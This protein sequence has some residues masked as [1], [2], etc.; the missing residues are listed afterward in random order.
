MAQKDTLFKNRP[1][2]PITVAEKIAP[3]KPTIEKS[4]LLEAGKVPFIIFL[5]FN[6][7]ILIIYAVLSSL[8]LGVNL[9][10]TVAGVP[11]FDLL[12]FPITLIFWFIWVVHNG[13]N[14]FLIL[15]GGYTAAKKGQN[16]VNCGLIGLAVFGVVGLIFGLTQVVL[17]VLGLGISAAGMGIMSDAMLGATM[18]GLGIGMIGF[19]AFCAFGF[20]ILG[21][22]V[23][24]GIG[25]IGGL[26]GGSSR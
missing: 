2:D 24:F 8:T 12:G 1:M 10:G 22:L 23:N 7:V 5:A 3:V 20:F 15:Y 16:T 19:G 26:I 13:I 21:L 9:V 11:E 14:P 18:G 4:T 6:L 17:S 25:A